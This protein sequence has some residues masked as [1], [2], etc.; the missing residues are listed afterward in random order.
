M[1]DE[2]VGVGLWIGNLHLTDFNEKETEKNNP[3]W[4]GPY[5][6]ISDELWGFD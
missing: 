4:A 5:F 6:Q 1:D 3:I 2:I